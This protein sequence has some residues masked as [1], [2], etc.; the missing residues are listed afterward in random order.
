MGVCQAGFSGSSRAADRVEAREVCGDQASQDLKGL[1][2]E[3]AWGPWGLEQW[4]DSISSG[5][6]KSPL[7]YGGEL[8]GKGKAGG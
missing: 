8:T 7:R 4:R 1:G 6:R 2:P 5:C 3:G